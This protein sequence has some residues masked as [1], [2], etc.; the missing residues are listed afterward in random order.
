MLRT[1]TFILSLAIHG[2]LAYVSLSSD[3][4]QDSSVAFEQGTGDDQF[5]IEQGIG[6]EGF[7][8]EGEAV[9]T[10]E[11]NET[12]TQVS[13][14]RPQID[15]VKPV[16]E[17][18]ETPPDDQ[19]KETEIVESTSGPEAEALPVEEEKPIEEVQQQPAQMATV[20]QLEQVAV[21]EQKAAGAK[22]EGG[23]T[24][25]R[26]AY[27]GKLSRKLQTTKINPHSRATGTVLVRFEVAP[28]GAL[29]SREVIASS[30]S[31]LLDNAAL[32]AI[33]RAAPFPPFPEGMNADKIVE[34]VPYRFSVR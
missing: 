22:Q 6:I 26:R 19:L 15:E 25:M 10:V 3:L 33:D 1:L 7:M 18:Q 4:L 27:L 13:E 17:A 9:E 31:Q 12:P 23:D 14:A 16:E 2:A 28:S 32:A 21:E 5:V 30:G 34:V 11:A 20:E 24:G 8:Q 29:L